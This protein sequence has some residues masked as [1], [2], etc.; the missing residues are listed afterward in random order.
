MFRQFFVEQMIGLIHTSFHIIDE[1]NEPV[2]TYGTRKIEEDFFERNL[3]LLKNIQLGITGDYPVILME[4]TRV[5]AIFSRGMQKGQVMVAGPVTEGPL[6]TAEFMRYHER[7]GM[8]ESQAYIPP[9]CPLNRFISGVLLLHW[10]LTGEEM[11]AAELWEKNKEHYIPTVNMPTRIS[12]DIFE[13]LENPG[14]HN[15]YEQEL[16]E[17]ESIEKGD[18]RSLARS[19][20]EVYEG[21]IGILAK[22]PLRSQKNIA[23]GNITLASRAA[24]RGGV[25]VEQSF[26]LADSLIRQVEEIGSVPEVEAFK[27][28]AQ[29]TYARLVSLGNTAG[30]EKRKTAVGNPLVARTKD[31]IFNQTLQRR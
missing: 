2:R 30:K 17:L 25:S 20:S 5:F 8:E 9:V 6:S 7:Y 28:E 18:V 14:M 10:H 31:Y 15:P 16:R 23:V 22:N 29:Y 12:H 26:S 11:T 3:G 13:R 21:E 24:I 27:R 4:E 19:I 1:K